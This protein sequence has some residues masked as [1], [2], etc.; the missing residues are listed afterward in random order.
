MYGG[1]FKNPDGTAF[2]SGDAPHLYRVWSGVQAVAYVNIYVAP[3][4]SAGIKLD[5]GYSVTKWRAFLP[6]NTDAGEPV[7]ASIRVPSAGF[8]AID[9]IFPTEGGWYVY[10]ISTGDVSIVQSSVVPY[11]Y[12]YQGYSRKN[13]CG[14]TYNRFMAG[15]SAVT[16]IENYVINGASPSSLPI[17]DG[18]AP[19]TAAMGVGYSNGFALIN[20]SG[21]KVF[22]YPVKYTPIKARVDTGQ[23][24]APSMISSDDVRALNSTE[25][26]SISFYGVGQYVF[27]RAFYTHNTTCSYGCD[28]ESGCI[29]SYSTSGN[30]ILLRN[31]I[32]SS[33]IVRRIPVK[34]SVYSGSRYTD[35]SSV[36]GF[37]GSPVS[38][39]GGTS[40]G[41]KISTSVSN[42]DGEYAIAIP[43]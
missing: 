34:T 17:V 23:I 42:T 11:S 10:G 8:H 3:V 37:G 35:N 22:Q 40:S 7:L 1:I 6:N 20:P 2:L 36:V 38:S 24:S 33:G 15:T 4:N 31:M 26:L 9:G 39:S 30:T 29:N 13:Q 18:Y 43:V 28:G 25:G 14:Y 5:Y 27:D 21:V 32:N 16:S 41:Y 19:Y 12:Y